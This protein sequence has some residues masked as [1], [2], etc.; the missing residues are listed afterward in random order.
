MKAKKPNPD[1]FRTQQN[2]KVIKPQ[3]LYQKISAKVNFEKA[4]PFIFI[5]VVILLISGFVFH[6]ITSAPYKVSV[7]FIRENP[8]IKAVVGK[9]NECHPWFPIEVPPFGKTDH[10]RLTFDVTGSKSSIEVSLLLMKKGGEWRITTA[11]YKDF[12]GLKKIL[13]KENSSS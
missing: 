5:L 12:Q 13:I 3:S 2:I 4:K 9:I 8:D 10:A 11:S 1:K 7:A 6:V